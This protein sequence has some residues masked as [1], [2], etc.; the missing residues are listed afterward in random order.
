MKFSSNYL[1]FIILLLAGCT[2]DLELPSK[3]YPYVITEVPRVSP[4]GASF[5]ADI[6]D[7]GSGKILNYGF[8][9]SEHPVP[10][11]KDYNV[12]FE[13]VINSGKYSYD[14]NSNLKDSIT[15]YVRACVTS[16][17][18]EVYGKEIA[19]NSQGCK[20]PGILGFS[21]TYGSIG[22]EVI[23]EGDNI[24][25][26]WKDYI[27]KFGNNVANI[28]R[29]SGNKI[30]TKVPLISKPEKVRISIQNAGKEAFSDDLFDLWFPWIRKDVYQ[31]KYNLFYSSTYTFN[32]KGY[33]LPQ[34]SNNLVEFDPENNSFT[35]IAHLPENS[36]DYPLAVAS[37][38]FVYMRLSTGLYK[39]NPLT[40]EWL[41]LYRFP[42]FSGSHNDYMFCLNNAV[43][44]GFG[45]NLSEFNETTLT[46]IPK[47][48]FDHMNHLVFLNAYTYNNAGYILQGEFNKPPAVYKYDPDNDTW[49]N[50]SNCPVLLQYQP[51]EFFCHF[52][53]QDKIY[54]DFGNSLDAVT[55]NG[56]LWQY[57][58]TTNSWS[59]FHEV[60]NRSAVGNSIAIEGKAYA[61]FGDEYWQFT[62]EKN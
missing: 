62:P 14:L 29:I 60:P 30:Y 46:W 42:E 26:S 1:F 39:F 35:T 49:E 54:T 51:T 55:Y 37:P 38:E 8:V 23:I 21:P 33:I 61:L 41:L 5:S 18:Y 50:V 59:R 22:T 44:L 53:M 40:S 31:Y 24:G 28:E 47:N 4:E 32:K 25:T 20:S 34:S 6:V 17:N 16:D 9:W 43:Y 57:D 27:V 2:K 19:F 13:P 7:P 36:G 15:Y 11:R 45:Q 56:F 10:T 12:I 48:P 58:I 3:D 52:L